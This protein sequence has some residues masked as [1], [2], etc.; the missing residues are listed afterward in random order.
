MSIDYENAPY[1]SRNWLE[2]SRKGYFEKRHGQIAMIAV[3]HAA[4]ASGVA[5]V[6][7]FHQQKNWCSA[8]SP[9]YAPHITYHYYIESNGLLY[10][11]NYHWESS[12]HASR[13]NDTSL[14][15]C[16]QGDLDKTQPTPQ[17]IA[18]LRWLLD[19]LRTDYRIER[20]R[21]FGHGELTA[22]GNDTSCPGRYL[23]PFV[24]A[25]R[26]MQDVPIELKKPV[27]AVDWQTRAIEILGVADA[28]KRTL[29]WIAVNSTEDHVKD[30]A[31]AALNGQWMEN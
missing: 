1:G 21:I 11:C 3:H 9:C 25:Y 18:S 22:Y 17:Q 30:R 16:L 12:W 15:I 5:A 23:L 24:R 8:A 19:E 2:T 31:L 29:E 20:G 7:R 10:L 4:A 26:A 27:E 14:G 13:A 28:H 6:N